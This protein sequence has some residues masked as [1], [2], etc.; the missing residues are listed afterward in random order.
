M[1]SERVEHAHWEGLCGGGGCDV[2]RQHACLLVVPIDTLYQDAH[3]Q[4]VIVC[5]SAI[6]E[7]KNV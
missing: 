2:A 1:H 4:S 5:V 3:G 7:E 6:C